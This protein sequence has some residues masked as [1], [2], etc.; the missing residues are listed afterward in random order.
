MAL[1]V[2]A[3]F[4]G[5]Y[6]AINLSGDHR[7]TANAR[8]D[9]IVELLKKD[10]EIVDAFSTGSIPKLTAIRNRADLDVMTV[11]H[12]GKHIR[13]K[14]PAQLLQEVQTSLSGYSTRVRRNGQAVTLTF[15]TWPN[16]DIVPVSRTVNDDGTVNYY[17][18]PD[19]VRGSWLK[20][21]P[22][23]FA[24]EI[25]AKASECGENFR[26][27]I[28]MI[29]HWNYIHSEYLTGY[30]IEV[31]AL[32]IFSGKLTDV[33]WD[34]FQFFENARTLAAA[35]L[36]HE[37]SFA[38]EYLSA[39]D[40]TEAVRRLTTAAEKARNAWALTYGAASDHRGAIDIWKQIF[41]DA[42]PSYG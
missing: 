8:K 25:D 20:S 35:S 28:K 11:L 5:F 21:R 12:F 13:G 4:D 2:N 32:R 39:T 29:K 15:Q 38:D 19:S 14:T 3:A 41:G 17:E 27:I 26:R 18:V 22:R 34:V 9:R 6:N 10:F 36:W 42:F 40:R 33:P 30:H 1:T 16:V 7:T 23:K 24:N 37:L 31:L